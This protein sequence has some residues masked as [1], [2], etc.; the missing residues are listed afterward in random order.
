MP[1]QI[2]YWLCLSANLISL[3]IQS[4]DFVTFYTWLFKSKSWSTFGKSEIK[5]C[6]W[7]GKFES[8][9]WPRLG[10][11]KSTPK[12][13]KTGLENYENSEQID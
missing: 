6:I 5:S 12:L 10:K 4:N 8:N 3:L 7:F 9:S 11:S 2:Q 13:F 1:S